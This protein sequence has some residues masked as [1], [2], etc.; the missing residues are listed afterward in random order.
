MQQAA[1]CSRAAPA[2][3]VARPVR[4]R[5]R[6]RARGSSRGASARNWAS[7]GPQPS[8]KTACA[9]RRQGRLAGDVSKRGDPRLGRDGFDQG[10]TRP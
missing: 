5:V 2:I 10:L 6:A 9:R 3:T 1:A 8:M 4:G 7:T